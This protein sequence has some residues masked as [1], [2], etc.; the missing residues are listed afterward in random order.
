MELSDSPA[1]ISSLL[2]EPASIT[3]QGIRITA[4]VNSLATGCRPRIVRTPFA[5]LCQR[6]CVLPSPS[7]VYDARLP[8]LKR[9]SFAS[10]ARDEITRKAVARLEPG[11]IKADV[12]QRATPQISV[13]PESENSL[14]WACRIA[15]ACEN[16]AAVDPDRKIESI[17]VI[18][19]R[20]IPKQAWNF[21]KVRQAAQ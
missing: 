4:A 19:A 18:Q 5:K 20:C 8:L 6:H 17:A 12:F 13:D 2:R 7:Q 10:Q 9:W 14:V 21:R 11:S 1:P 3:T 16:P 15:R